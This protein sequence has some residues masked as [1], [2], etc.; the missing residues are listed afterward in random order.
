MGSDPIGRKETVM[1]LKDLNIGDVVTIKKLVGG[2]DIKKLFNKMGIS[3]GL[4][5]ELLEKKEDGG[6]TVKAGI[7]EFDL[8]PELADAI[9]AGEQFKRTNDPVLLGCG[10]GGLDKLENLSAKKA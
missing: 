2:R 6:V 3:S 4:D 7:R 9:E 5:L 1:K 10:G 8:T